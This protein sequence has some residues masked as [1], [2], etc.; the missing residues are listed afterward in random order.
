MLI[1]RVM[2][3][4]EKSMTFSL[5]AVMVNAATARSA[6][7]WRGGGAR[8]QRGGPGRQMGNQRELYR[9][10]DL[11]YQKPRE[12]ETERRTAGGARGP[13][14]LRECTAG[15][16]LDPCHLMSSFL[17]AALPHPISPAP[18]PHVKLII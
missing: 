12:R 3:G 10:S 9:G 6:F 4:L 15:P 1:P 13:D 2:K 17:P 11:E 5:S 7:C 8:G 16:L 14:W 18:L